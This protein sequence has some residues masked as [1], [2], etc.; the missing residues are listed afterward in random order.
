MDVIRH[1]LGGDANRLARY[2]QAYANEALAE[3][4]LSSGTFPFLLVLARRAGINQNE[5]SQ[6]LNIDKAMSARAI[7]RLVKIGYIARKRDLEDLR[8]F[9]LYLTDKGKEVVPIVKKVMT[10]WNETIERD[11]SEDEKE[12]LVDLLGRVLEN[13]RHA[14]N[15]L[16]HPFTGSMGSIDED[17]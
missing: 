5:I 14:R 3:Y 9:K 7:K 12:K 10:Y 8:A 2:T 16:C 1:T 13:A 6:E 15:E 4:Q 11:L 17:E